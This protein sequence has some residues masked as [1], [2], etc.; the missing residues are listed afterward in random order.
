M[1]SLSRFCAAKKGDCVIWNDTTYPLEDEVTKW[2]VH[3]ATST[4]DRMFRD[5]ALGGVTYCV[6]FLVGGTLSGLS[7]ITRHLDVK[8]GQILGQSRLRYLPTSWLR[9]AVSNVSPYVPYKYIFF[10]TV[11][12]FWSTYM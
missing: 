1:S 10:C 3:W 7:K 2:L 11:L 9:S 5:Q 6:A 8:V 4:P 12:T